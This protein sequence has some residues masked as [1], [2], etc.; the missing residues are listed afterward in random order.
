MKPLAQEVSIHDN[1]VLAYEVDAERR[2]ITLR[3]RFDNQQ[4]PEYTDV[5]FEKVLAYHFEGDDFATILLDIEEI[6]LDQLVERNAELFDRM[7]RF[8]W[9]GAWNDSVEGCLAYFVSK[10]G[11]A[12]E[13]TSACGM[14]GWVIAGACR[15]E[16]T[17]AKPG[18]VPIS[19]DTG[20]EGAD[21]CQRAR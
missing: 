1:R 17:N 6:L 10:G 16:I 13:I 4:P 5:V 7:R 15:F 21:R 3:T 11:R 19:L 9:P 18:A 2:Q 8:P 14:D 20:Q 12:F